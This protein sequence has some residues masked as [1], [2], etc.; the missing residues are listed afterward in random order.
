MGQKVDN[1]QNEDKTQMTY[2]GM[3]H[4]SMLVQSLSKGQTVG[5]G[6]A[7]SRLQV[8]H[9]PWVGHGWAMSGPWV[10]HEWAMSGPWVG[11][12]RAVGDGQTKTEPNFEP[13]PKSNRFQILSRFY[14]C[15]ML[16]QS[17]SNGQTVGHVQAM[18]GPWVTINGTQT[19]SRVCPRP[20]FV[21]VQFLPKICP[22]GRQLAL[23]H[24]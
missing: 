6:H 23:V 1:G 4:H 24:N 17:L 11:H 14:L 22:I 8:G 21:H 15:S 5:H 9:G 3:Q 13:E 10:G 19:M 2:I 12:G 7:M 18:G 16:I 20:E